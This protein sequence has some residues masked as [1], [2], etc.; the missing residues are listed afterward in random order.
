MN[1]PFL[2]RDGLFTFVEMSKARAIFWH[3]RD[4]RIEDN[5][6][7]NKALISGLDV[8]AVFIF[9]WNILSKLEDRRDA[10]V[11]FI[12]QEIERLAKE[13]EELGGSLRVYYGKPENVWEEIVEE[14]K[15]SKVFTNR[16]YEPDALERDKKIHS[17]L[18]EHEIEFIG[19]KD[20]VLFEK[21]EVLKDDGDPYVVYTPYMRKWKEV[22]K[23][24][25]QE[26]YDNSTFKNFHS[27]KRKE[28]PTLAHM[29]FEDFEFEFPSRE[30]DPK[31]LDEYA[32]KRDIPSVKGTTRISMHLRFGTVSIRK[33][34][35]LAQEHSEKW[36]NE[37]IWRDF[38]QSIIYHYPHSATDSF[39]SKYDQIPWINNEDHFKAWCEGRTGYPI[40]DAGMR[41]LNETGFMHN[42]VR[43]VVASFLTKH[44]LIDW[45]WGE[46]YFAQKLLDYELASNV[47]GWQWAAGSGVDAAPYFRV[48]NPSSQEKKFDPDRKY[49]RKWVPEVDSSSYPEPIVEHKMARQRA[50]DTYK[51]ALS[52]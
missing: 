18:K 39:R 5:A 46:R 51:E 32:D 33:L 9:D 44:L 38:Y 40:V 17:F 48:F 41:E 7:L 37:L 24:N 30:I 13:Y 45:R 15:P 11:L 3:R 35:K 19:A 16:D 49:I 4:L 42:R 27:S 14:F 34:L 25:P 29:G 31:T 12:H 22:L 6:G 50:I 21:N 8:Q 43:M 52:D 26:I 10:R 36:L 2:A 1:S 20:H 47:G 23:Q 28:I